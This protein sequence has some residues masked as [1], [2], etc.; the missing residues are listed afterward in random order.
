MPKFFVYI[1]QNCGEDV[2][3]RQQKKPH[4]SRCGENEKFVKTG[5]KNLIDHLTL[6]GIKEQ[7][8]R[9]GDKVVD[10]FWEVV[11]KF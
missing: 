7:L 8:S 10:K 3:C 1:C 6:N 2:I 9:S 5:E 11:D 4:C